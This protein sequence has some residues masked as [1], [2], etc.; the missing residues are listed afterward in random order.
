MLEHPITE[1]EAATRHQATT[2][3]VSLEFSSSK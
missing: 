1:V 3:F 2:L